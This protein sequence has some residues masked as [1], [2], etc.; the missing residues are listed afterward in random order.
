MTI[1]LRRMFNVNR[2]FFVNG[3]S[4]LLIALV[5]WFDSIYW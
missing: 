4:V 1:Y 3:E 5:V 2:D